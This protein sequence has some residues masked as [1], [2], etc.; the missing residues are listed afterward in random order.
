MITEELQQKL[1]LGV[2]ENIPDTLSVKK[3]KSLNK[4]VYI[5]HVSVSQNNSDK[6]IYIYM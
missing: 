6:N 4:L 1:R 5:C 2:E 3:K